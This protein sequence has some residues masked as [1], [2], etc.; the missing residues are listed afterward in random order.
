MGEAVKEI[1][2]VLDEAGNLHAKLQA[3]KFH[4]RPIQSELVEGTQ[5]D[6]N[7]EKFA[8]ALFDLIGEPD[9]ETQYKALNELE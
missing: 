1:K 8:D 5:F 4:L 9:S 2:L 7:W 6:T 3:L